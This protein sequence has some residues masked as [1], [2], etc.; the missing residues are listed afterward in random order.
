MGLCKD[1]KLL[2]IYKILQCILIIFW[3][4]FSII[5]FLGFNGYIRVAYLFQNKDPAAG[6]VGI[7]ESLLFDINCF[8]SGFNLYR[9]HTAKVKE[10]QFEVNMNTTRIVT[11]MLTK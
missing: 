4:I 3:L 7:L 9:V 11:K 5:G 1:P 6:I 10:D 2:K 8:L